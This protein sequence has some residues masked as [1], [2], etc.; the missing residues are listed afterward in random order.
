MTEKEHKNGAETE[1]FIPGIQSGSPRSQFEPEE[2]PPKD[3]GNVVL[4][5]IM[6]HGIGTLIA[7]NVFITIAPM[8]YQD[9]KLKQ[10]DPKPAYVANFMN[11][12][13]ICSQFPN[14]LVN[15]IGM[16]SEK[17]NLLF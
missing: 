4:F 1:P 12:V 3:R 13:C 16:F 7:W 11:Y 10:A 5:I 17:G 15:M 14:L 6:L 9:L 8:Y 2:P